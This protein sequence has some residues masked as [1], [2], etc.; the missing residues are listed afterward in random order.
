MLEEKDKEIEKL[1]R[2]LEVEKNT[3]RNLNKE[4]QR[5][6]DIIME[7]NIEEANKVRKFEFTGILKEKKENYQKEVQPKVQDMI[8]L[9]QKE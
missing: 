8:F 3:N 7:K 1:K 5:Y 4:C 2:Q 9:H 6:F